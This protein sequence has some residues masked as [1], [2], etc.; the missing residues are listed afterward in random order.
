MPDKHIEREPKKL[1]S[2]LDKRLSCYVALAAAAGV[3]LL[4]SAEPIGAEVVFTPSDATVK[5]LFGGPTID[6]NND[7]IIDFT[8]IPIGQEHGDLIGITGPAG[9]AVM[10]RGRF[11]SRTY[12]N[13]LLHTRRLF[14]CAISNLSVAGKASALCWLAP[15][16]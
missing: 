3:G 9:N 7:G 2:V 6:L 8:L 14:Q 4:A 13:A 15:A 5:C 10:A 11:H 1:A 16:D 12:A